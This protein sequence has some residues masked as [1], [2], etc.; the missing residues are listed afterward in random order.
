VKF[1][2][3]GQNIFPRYL[4]IIEAKTLQ[5]IFNRNVNSFIDKITLKKIGHL[6][7][8]LVLVMMAGLSSCAVTKNS[9]RRAFYYRNNGINDW[10]FK[11]GGYAS[12]HPRPPIN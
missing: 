7:A 3:G 10:N 2:D 4:L 12:G 8:L 11:L 5:Q 9:T 1:T 6:A